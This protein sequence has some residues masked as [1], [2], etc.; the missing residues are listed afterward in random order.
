MPD[1]HMTERLHKY[2]SA[3]QSSTFPYHSAK[4]EFWLGKG[5]AASFSGFK[6]L[7]CQQHGDQVEEIICQV[8]LQ[9]DGLDAFI[10]CMLLC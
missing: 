2:T 1:E 6:P 8:T 9:K 7:F 10:F 5:G 4:Q 3:L